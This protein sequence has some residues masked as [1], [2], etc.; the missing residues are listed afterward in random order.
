[1]DDLLEHRD[2][3]PNDFEEQLRELRSVAS[4]SAEDAPR[5]DKKSWKPKT[6]SSSRNKWIIRVL[7]VFLV[8]LTLGDIVVIRNKVSEPVLPS[9]LGGPP[10][11]AYVAPVFGKPLYTPTVEAKDISQEDI[12]SD[13]NSGPLYDIPP[14]PTQLPF[15]EEIEVGDLPIPPD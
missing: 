2:S 10:T 14:T 12:I 4:S 15:P 13:P 5:L 8:A 6:I 9:Y 7:M 11:P 3:D 1:M